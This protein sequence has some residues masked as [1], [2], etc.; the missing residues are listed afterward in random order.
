MRQPCKNRKKYLR[1]KKYHRCGRQKDGLRDLCFDHPLRIGKY[2]CSTR[3]LRL[4]PC[5]ILAEITEKFV[6]ETHQK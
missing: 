4:T 1:K 2:V 6:S 3:A 5:M